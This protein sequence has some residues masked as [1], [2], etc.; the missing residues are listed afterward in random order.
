[1]YTFT[2]KWEKSMHLKKVISVS[3]L[4]IFVVYSSVVLGAKSLS[5]NADNFPT[6]DPQVAQF[7]IDLAK[8]DAPPI[9]TLPIKKARD[10]FNAVQK[11]D[12]QDLLPVKIQKI[13]VGNDSKNGVSVEIEIIRPIKSRGYLPVIIYFHGGGWILGGSYSHARLARELAYG[14]NAAVA[15]V[16]FTLSPEAHYPLPIEQAYLATDYLAK[17]G[18]KLNLDTSRIALAGDSVG[19]NMATITALLAKERGG[20]EILYQALFYPVT[21]AAMDTASYKEFGQKNYWLTQKAME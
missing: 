13:K 18:K 1:M 8:Q 7:L 9:Y 11:T 21:D 3:N 14:A 5:T 10:I 2:L 17:F 4:A 12:P 16:N 15:F 19:G 20:P 6:L